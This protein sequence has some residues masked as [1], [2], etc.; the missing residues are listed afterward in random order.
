VT[1]IGLPIQQVAAAASEV[2]A[3]LLDARCGRIEAGYDADL[4]VLDNELRVTA[5]MAD[6]KWCW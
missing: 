5:V 6:G 3:R 4:V 1:E 2:P